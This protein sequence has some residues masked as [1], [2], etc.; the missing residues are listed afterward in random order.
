MRRA[1]LMIA[2]LALP[3]YGAEPKGPAVA[4]AARQRAMDRDESRAGARA[5]AEEI[6]R[7]RNELTALGAA[8]AAGERAV[9]DKGARLAALNAAEADLSARMGENQTKLVRLLGALQMY[10]RD[11]PPALLVSPRN[12]EDAVNAAILMQAAAPELE[13][14]ARAFS[15]EAKHL[16]L[17]RRQVV[18]ADGALFT[19]ESDAA[20]R[21]AEIER[22]IAEKTALERKLDAEAATA[23]QAARRLAAQARALGQIVRGL[24]AREPDGIGDLH[25]IPPVPGDPSRRFGEPWPGQSR[26]DGWAWRPS[27]GAVVVSPVAAR[28]DYVGPLKGWGVVVILRLSGDRHAVLAGLQQS[29]V[30]VGA[31]VAAGEP[32]GRMAAADP[33]AHD[34]PLTSPELYLEV[35]KGDQPVDP[36][37]WFGQT[38]ARIGR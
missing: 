4:D 19:A 32:I 21:R 3:L 9:G 35:R 25:L 15:T 8:K 20:D 24:D 30:R 5:A 33:L 18:L 1:A 7:L 2:V 27:P 37:R 34:K 6:A 23:D 10:R 17:L 38:T 14:R 12:A 16:Q 11:P 31:S 28:I 13:R 26:S 22:A 29:T 36:S